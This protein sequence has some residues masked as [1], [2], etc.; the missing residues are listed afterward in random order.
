MK[1]IISQLCCF[2]TQSYLND[3]IFDNSLKNKAVAE[4]GS[5]SLI[6]TNEMI[7]PII[8]QSDYAEEFL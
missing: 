2:K 1:P 6:D 5:S 4:E 7:F 8:A 3:Y